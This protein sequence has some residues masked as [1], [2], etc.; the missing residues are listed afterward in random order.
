MWQEPRLGSMFSI[1]RPSHIT[2][3]QSWP[4]ARPAC[5]SARSTIVSVNGVIDAAKLPALANDC[6][7][8][9]INNDPGLKAF[10]ASNASAQ[11][12]AER[13]LVLLTRSRFDVYPPINATPTGAH[14]AIFVPN[15]P[16]QVKGNTKGRPAYVWLSDENGGCPLNYARIVSVESE[17]TPIMVG[18]FSIPDNQLDECLTQSD[19]RT[20][21]P[22]PA[23]SGATKSQPHGFQESRSLQHV[24]W[25]WPPRDRHFRPA[26]PSRSRLR[27]YGSARHRQ[28]VSSLQGRAHLLGR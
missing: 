21:R 4:R 12:K 16:A 24:V 17:I 18:A 5:R 13:Y 14:S 10:L 11:A 26:E 8:M 20:Q 15:R 3:M 2:R 19:H 25:S 28:N 6:I 7:H 1:Q 9:V 22:A 27:T 23:T